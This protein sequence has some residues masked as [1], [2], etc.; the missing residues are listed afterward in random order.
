MYRDAVTTSPTTD[1]AIGQSG[2]CRPFSHT[3]T[4]SEHPPR[5]DVIRPRSAAAEGPEAAAGARNITLAISLLNPTRIS[6]PKKRK[7]VFISLQEL[8]LRSNG[9]CEI[10][11]I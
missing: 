1:T 8:P 2:Y 6:A 4:I 11:E 10:R 9:S 7:Y 3:K 5:P